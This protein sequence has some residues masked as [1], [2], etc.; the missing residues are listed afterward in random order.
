MLKLSE[1][2]L[3]QNEIHYPNLLRQTLLEGELQGVPK[4]LS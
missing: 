4:S 2:A 1:P 3:A